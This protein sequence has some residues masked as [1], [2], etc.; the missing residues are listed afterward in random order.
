[1]KR[2]FPTEILNLAAVW[3]SRFLCFLS[4]KVECNSLFFL[5]LGAVCAFLNNLSS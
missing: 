3:P 1:M 2:S 5:F 4:L